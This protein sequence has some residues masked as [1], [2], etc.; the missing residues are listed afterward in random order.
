MNN[1]GIKFILF[2]LGILIIPMIFYIIYIYIA[3]DFYGKINNLINKKDSFFYKFLLLILFI[4]F[5]LFGKLILNIFANY[6]LNLI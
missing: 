2:L 6:V 5:L 1:E 3:S 4:L